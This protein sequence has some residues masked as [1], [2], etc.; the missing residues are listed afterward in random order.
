MNKLKLYDCK[1][2]MLKHAIKDT[3][4]KVTSHV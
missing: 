1:V 3:L 4:Q 2:V